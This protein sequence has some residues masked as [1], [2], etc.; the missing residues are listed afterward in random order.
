MRHAWREQRERRNAAGQKERQPELELDQRGRARGP[1]REQPRR[2]AVEKADRGSEHDRDDR[3]SPSPGL[4]WNA[5]RGPEDGGD[6]PRREDDRRGWSLVRDVVRD[7]FMNRR[8]RASEPIVHL[9]P[10]NPSI[11]VPRVPRERR[12]IHQ[13]DAEEVTRKCLA[14]VA[15]HGATGR[16][17]PPDAERDDRLGNSPDEPDRDR[18]A[19]L[20][21]DEKGRAHELRVLIAEDR[22]RASR[23]R[24]THGGA[25]RTSARITSGSVLASVSPKAMRMT[26]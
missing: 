23:V 19:V 3:E 24:S 13:R 9:A 12:L 16:D 14:R 18:C 10:T 22:E 2:V 25:R 5:N 1:E 4:E 15:I 8:D 11:D 20:Q 7:G 17:R 6:E 21:V 26:S